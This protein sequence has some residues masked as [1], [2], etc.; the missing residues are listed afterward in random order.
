MFHVGQVPA[1]ISSYSHTQKLQTTTKM[2]P[3]SSQ[4]SYHLSIPEQ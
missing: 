3:L 4:A 2:F 1:I